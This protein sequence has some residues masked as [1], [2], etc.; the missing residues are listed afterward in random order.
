MT[1]YH[2][3][4]LALVD[5]VWRRNLWIYCEADLIFVLESIKTI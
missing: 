2:A 4:Y 5:R 1:E 3:K